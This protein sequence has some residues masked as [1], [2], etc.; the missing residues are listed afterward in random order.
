LIV[1]AGSRYYLPILYNII[2]AVKHFQRNETT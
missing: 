1:C 2:D